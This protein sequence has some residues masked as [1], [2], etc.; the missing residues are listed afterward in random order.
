MLRTFK[1]KSLG[2]MK[3]L[4]FILLQIMIMVIN[5]ESVDQ[6]NPLDFPFKSLPV[7]DKTRTQT[8][9]FYVKH[10]VW[11]PQSFSLIPKEL[12]SGYNTLPFIHK[13]GLKAE[14]VRLRFRK[15]RWKWRRFPNSNP[16]LNP[17]VSNNKKNWIWKGTTAIYT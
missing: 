14:G 4:V 17:P 12:P 7:A 5:T 11:S 6:T 2:V 3:V 10:K 8:E 15:R 1:N 9:F 16:Y 13:Y